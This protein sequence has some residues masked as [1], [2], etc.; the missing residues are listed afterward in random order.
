MKVL[1]KTPIEELTDFIE[2]I[3]DP[4]ATVLS[5][6]RK[7]TEVSVQSHC[8]QKSN[9]RASVYR[10]VSKNGRQWQIQSGNTV[11][12]RYYG[13]CATEMEAARLYDEKSILLHG[14]KAKTNFNYSKTELEGILS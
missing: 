4:N 2:G 1:K 14:L 13:S 6:F 9:S 11:N 10:G 3:E 12:K 8:I 5:A 7:K